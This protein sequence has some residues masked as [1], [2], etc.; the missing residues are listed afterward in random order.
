MGRDETRRD[1]RLTDDDPA[2]KPKPKPKPKLKLKL[3]KRA[4]FSP[5]ENSRILQLYK[6]VKR[7]KTGLLG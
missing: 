4:S 5:C 2:G 6:K 1:E 7:E 3:Q